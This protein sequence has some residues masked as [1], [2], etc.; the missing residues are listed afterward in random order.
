MTELTPGDRVF[1]YL[2]GWKVICVEC[3][4]VQCYRAVA[5]EWCPNRRQSDYGKAGGRGSICSA[6]LTA[7]GRHGRLKLRG[8]VADFLPLPSRGE[9]PLIPIIKRTGKKVHWIARNEIRKA[10]TRKGATPIL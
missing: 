10:P 1:Y 9:V 4:D 5:P 3:G 8:R 7:I 6:E 2:P